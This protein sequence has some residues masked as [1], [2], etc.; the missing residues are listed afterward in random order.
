M[1]L[2][3]LI[4]DDFEQHSLNKYKTN[5]NYV[6]S[7]NISFSHQIVKNGKRSLKLTYHFGGW[8]SGNAAMPILFKEKLS[9]DLM[10]QKIALWIHGNGRIPWIRAVILDGCGHR[11]TIN[12]TEDHMSWQGWKYVEGLIDSSWTLPLR[13][14]QIYVVETDKK[15]QNDSSIGGCIFFDQLRFVY[16]DDEDFIGPTFHG[17]KPENDVVFKDAFQFSTFVSDNMSGVDAQSIHMSVNGELVNHRYSHDLNKISYDFKQMREGTYH[18]IVEASDCAGNKSVPF[19]EKAI[20]VD[21]SPDQ[22]K[23]VLSKVTPNQTAVEYTSTP[24][25]TFHLIDDKSGVEEESIIVMI[26]DIKQNVVYD[27]HTGWGY[28][29]SSQHLSEGKHL[30]TIKAADRAGNKCAPFTQT[31]TVK[32]IRHP[33]NI[34]AFSVSVIPDTHSEQYSQLAFHSVLKESTEFVIQMGDMVD[35][36]TKSEFNDLKN[37]LSILGDKPLL[38]VP[39]NHES[40]QG[41]I[42]LYKSVFGSPTYHLIY[43]N[44][45]FVFLN[46]AFNQS[47]SKSDSTQ[48]SYLEHLLLNNQQDNIVIMTHVPTRD[49]F[50][51]AHNMSKEDAVKLEHILS[52]Y[53][54][55]HKL[56]SVT[57]LFGHLH[58]IDQ[59]QANGVNYFITGN[60]AQ[61][62]YVSTDRGNILGHGILHIINN[63]VNFE[64]KPYVE[65]IRIIYNHEK[66]NHLQLEVGKVLSLQVQIKVNKQASQYVVDVSGFDLIRKKW[67]SNNEDSVEVDE[68]GKIYA[69]NQGMAL[70]SVEINN[71][72]SKLKVIVK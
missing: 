66:I 36:A 26:N 41:N 10:P 42:E 3:A 43:G 31:F 18:I 60:S 11:K 46:T 62:S 65:D 70:I 63:H 44:T 23:P 1:A 69:I 37:H 34:K 32:N 47:I 64:F 13:V 16:I 71:K 45:L 25:V 50:G 48:F 56:V 72:Q 53:K 5:H 14:E 6:K 58:V 68:H 40:F 33:N 39:G 55:E 54:R 57:V 51:T 59:W 30:L 7:Y 20:T 38:S 12:L 61:K 22:D 67:H 21:L 29:I 4:L 17:T 9:T 24:R 19:L 49:R 35:Q 2:K 28:A 27:S 8:S 15:Y 52:E